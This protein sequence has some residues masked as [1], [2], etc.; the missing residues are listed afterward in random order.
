MV[1]FCSQ[2][3]EYGLWMSCILYED[4]WFSVASWY[5]QSSVGVRVVYTA[6]S[7][8]G[9]IQSTVLVGMCQPRRR[10]D[11]Q[12][13][14][15]RTVRVSNSDL[16]TSRISV[17]WAT[18][19]AAPSGVWHACSDAALICEFLLS[20]VGCWRGT[21]SRCFRCCSETLAVCW[22]RVFVAFVAAVDVFFDNGFT[23]ELDQSVG[24][25][26]VGHAV[27]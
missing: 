17:V 10:T 27:V 14:W 21:A 7:W 12:A 15:H 2:W 23:I 1:M 13:W 25:W 6:A 22:L 24:L 26:T 11:P 19:C 16:S 8:A 20:T 4:C 3:S 5:R 9:S 18:L